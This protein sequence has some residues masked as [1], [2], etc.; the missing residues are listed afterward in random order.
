LLSCAACFGQT[1]Y[2]GLTPGSS[3]RADAARVLVRPV[4][5]L[6][7]T[8]VEYKSHS[9]LTLARSASHLRYQDCGGGLL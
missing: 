5:E 7:K 4:K 1:S 8:L 6:S 3:M 9:V 2:K